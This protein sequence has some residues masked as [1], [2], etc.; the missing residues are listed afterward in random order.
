VAFAPTPMVMVRFLLMWPTFFPKYKT[1]R[2]TGG[3]HIIRN[4][5]RD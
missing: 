1:S 2:S 5:A 3:H 4:V